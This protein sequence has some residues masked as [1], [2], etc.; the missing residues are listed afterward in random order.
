[1]QTVSAEENHEIRLKDP[2]K[3]LLS[4]SWLEIGISIIMVFDF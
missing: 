2:E 4:G 3:K 1:M